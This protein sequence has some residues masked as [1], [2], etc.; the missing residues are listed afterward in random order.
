MFESC[1]VVRP[2]AD[3]LEHACDVLVGKDQTKVQELAKLKNS[4]EVYKA[5]LT[6]SQAEK[7]EIA[8]NPSGTPAKAKAKAKGT[9]SASSQGAIL[10]NRSSQNSSKTVSAE[11][12]E[13]PR[14]QARRA[15]HAWLEG[16]GFGLNR[17][18]S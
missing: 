13:K 18:Y 17:S 10:A 14:R 4:A 8:S 9:S 1:R 7:L 16:F 11:L 3:R 6:W 12:S 2:K 15:G 5:F